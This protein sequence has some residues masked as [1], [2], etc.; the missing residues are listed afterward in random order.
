MNL[1]STGSGVDSDSKFAKQDWTRTKKITVRTPPAEMSNEPE[2]GP[3]PDYRSRLPQDSA[4]FLW[5][6]SRSQKFGKNRARSHFS[7]SAVA[8]VC[9]GIY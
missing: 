2:V 3:D 9:V 8:G 1:V 5:T 6:Q 4:F 7:I